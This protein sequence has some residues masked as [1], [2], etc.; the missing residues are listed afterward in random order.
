[1]AAGPIASAVAPPDQP[2]SSPG[3]DNALKRRQSD[4]QAH[5]NKRRR[6]S[7]EDSLSP[8]ILEDLQNPVQLILQETVTLPSKTKL[9][10]SLDGKEG[11]RRR[12]ETIDERKRGRRLFGALL[13]TLS[14]G[15]SSAQ[16]RRSEIDRK[17]QAKLKL[18]EKEYDE[19]TQNKHD[20]HM[21]ARKRD[22][23]VY[24][25]QSM[26]VRHYNAMALAH[27]LKT[28][29]EPVLYYK[30]WHLQPQE[31]ARIQVQIEESKAIIVSEKA[32]FDRKHP[33]PDQQDQNNVRQMS[34]K[35]ISSTVTDTVGSTADNKKQME[36]TPRS[37]SSANPT[38][39]VTTD[40]T[41]AATTDHSE[42]PM[43][44]ANPANYLND[45]LEDDSFEVVMEEIEDTLLVQIDMAADKIAVSGD[46]RIQRCTTVANGTTYGYLLAVPPNGKYRATIFLIHGFPDLSMGWRYQIPTLLKMG[47]RVVAPDCIGYGRSDAPEFT[48]QTAWK[49]G[50]K[51]C[52]TDMKEI[53]NQLGASQIILGGHDWYVSDHINHLTIYIFY[54]DFITHIFAI[55]TPYS[56][57][58]PEFVPLEQVVKRIPFFGYQL[59]FAHGG[60]EH[61]LNTKNDIR[62]FLIS[63]YGGRTPKGEV[64]MSVMSGI[65]LD[66]LPD[67]Q[68]SSILSEEELDYYATEFSRTGL[69]GP[70][71]WYRTRAQNFK[72]EREIQGRTIDVPVLFV[73]A[74]NDQ[75][76]RPELSKDMAKRLQHVTVREVDAGHW[77]LWQAPEACNQVLMEW[78]EEVVFGNKAKL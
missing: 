68:P 67:L 32:D 16:R 46:P 38:T 77:A 8:Q 29:S 5:D 12:L 37:P 76:L 70:L 45:S 7:T 36:D 69:H 74:I 73:R 56:P 75:A 43:N 65:K 22:G 40:T 62:Q 64:G 53:A 26:E 39:T 34:T 55:C 33:Q 11:G 13:G 18:Q 6:L 20:D 14:Q 24:C 48:E 47:L 44:L 66:K 21:A 61:I 27:F 10:G 28:K 9:N 23:I 2:Q 58:Q 52:A 59:H 71:S 19:L 42:T 63:L 41:T 49:Y 54:P 57:V 51:K 30:P 35:N 17:Q 3:L 72:E 15:S 4:S 50:I 25:R 60:L 1:M 78:F 31:K